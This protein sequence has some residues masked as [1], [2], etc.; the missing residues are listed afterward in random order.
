M[1]INSDINSP[2]KFLNSLIEATTKNKLLWAKIESDRVTIKYIVLIDIPKTKK[3]LKITLTELLGTPS[4]SYLM[5]EFNLINNKVIF[6]SIEGNR[7]IDKI[8][9]LIKKIKKQLS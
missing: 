7:Y 5:S 6:N 3:Y 4:Y 8:Y 9:E 2:L 1:T